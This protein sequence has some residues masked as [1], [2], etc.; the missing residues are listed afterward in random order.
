M[1]VVG[2]W[3]QRGWCGRMQLRLL[4]WLRG[5]QGYW[6]GLW[7][8]AGAHPEEGET[9]REQLQRRQQ[10]KISGSCRVRPASRLSQRD[11]TASV[12]GAAQGA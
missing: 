5:C 1:P 4:G 12:R 2:R 6:S 3:Y 9:L 11:T 7:I 10:M 8:E